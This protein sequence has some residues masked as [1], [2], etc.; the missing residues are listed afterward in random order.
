M[1]PKNAFRK[2][3]RE[4]VQELQSAIPVRHPPWYYRALMLSGRTLEVNISVAGT[5]RSIHDL[6]Q[7]V[8]QRIR[9]KAQVAARAGNVGFARPRT[10]GRGGSWA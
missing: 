3:K 2:K 9:R 10:R 7:D 1:T 6:P 4:E 5:P 8:Q